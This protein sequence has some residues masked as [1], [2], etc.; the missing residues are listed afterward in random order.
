MCWTRRAWRCSGA[1]LLLGLQYRAAFSPLFTQLPQVLQILSCVA[2]LSILLAACLLLATPC[3]HQ[4]AEAGHATERL[5]RR[6]SLM[7]Q[8][9]L[10]PLTIA[11]GI[12]VAIGF[13]PSTSVTTSGVA[14]GMFVLVALLVWF[15]VPTLSSLRR[16]PREEAMK[17]SRQSL[18][19]RIVQALTELRV[20]LPGAQALFGFQVSAVL[21]KRIAQISDVSRAVHLASTGMVVV[22]IILLLA[23]ATYHR[24][25]ASGEAQ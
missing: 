11:L 22:A 15:A 7:L 21:T 6:A 2:L 10:L 20:V 4:I 24:I 18:E 9:S 14:G 3:F 23:P 13:D 17:D 25:A 16:K 19:A 5:V 12:D 8:A 1:Q